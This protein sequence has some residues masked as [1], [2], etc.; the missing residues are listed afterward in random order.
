MNI[1]QVLIG[2]ELTLLSVIEI[3]AHSIR[4]HER[5]PEQ[6]AEI[7]RQHEEQDWLEGR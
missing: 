7:A 2:V 3:V 5:H 6:S 1:W 4:W